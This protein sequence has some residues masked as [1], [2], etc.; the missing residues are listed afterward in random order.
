MS[1]E[2]I[3][4]LDAL[5]EKFGV[6]ID[7]SSQNVLPYAKELMDKLIR[8]EIATSI[9]LIATFI[10]LFV[11]CLVVAI[12]SI[13]KTNEE[14]WDTAEPVYWVAVISTVCAIV[15]GIVMFG[16]CITQ[17]HDI[18]TCLTFPEKIIFDYITN[19]NIS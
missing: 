9:A 5:C 19:A 17:G 13:P 15:F 8:Y 14:Y 2:I 16:V 1:N 10:I 3:K 12:K 6:A 7:W 11:T 18:I 4:V